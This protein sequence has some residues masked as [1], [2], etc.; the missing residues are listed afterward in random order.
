M[1]GQRRVLVTGGTGLLGHALQ[2]IV[3][4]REPAWYFACSEDADLRSPLQTDLLFARVRPTHVVHLAARVGGLFANMSDNAGFLVD[5]LRINTNVLE[6]C[7][8]HGVLK[9]VTCLSTCV[10]PA[11]APLPLS[12]GNLH[13]GPPHPSNEGY[14]YAKRAAEVLSRHLARATGRPYVCVIPVNM[15]GPHDN[16]DADTSH[17][18]PALIRKACEQT[19][20]RV[21]GT[22]SP[23]R[24]FLFSYDAARML[25]WAL[26]NYD[27]ASTPLMMAPPV[28]GEVSI[29]TLATTV[30]LL[31]G[32]PAIEFDDDPAADGQAIKTARCDLPNFEYTSLR[33]GLE[34]TIAWYLSSPPP[35]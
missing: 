13:D 19:V 35:A 24:Q 4:D 28:Q 14:A 22:G 30:Q 11:D 10:F 16:F 20:L 23:R 1:S 6:A 7:K 31:A 34:Q 5:N 29:R 21:R 3:G 17:V 27:D 2:R 26:D 25:V 12:A 9:T 18:V 32:C 33:D 8:N 15:Y